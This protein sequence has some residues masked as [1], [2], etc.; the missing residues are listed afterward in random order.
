M[1]ILGGKRLVAKETMA[2]RDLIKMQASNIGRKGIRRRIVNNIGNKLVAI[3]AK[4]MTRSRIIRVEITAKAFTTI[5]S[6][7]NLHYQPMFRYRGLITP[8][9]WH[10]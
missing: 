8:S 7:T 6:N 2:A 5:I 4:S 10:I 3:M 9:Q 1:E